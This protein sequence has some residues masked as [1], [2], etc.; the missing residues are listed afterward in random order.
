MGIKDNQATQ[1]K[2][3]WEDKYS[4]QPKF[5][6]FKHF[7]NPKNPNDKMFVNLL[8]NIQGK[9]ILEIGCGNG[10]ISLYWEHPTYSI[11]KNA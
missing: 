5:Q 7:P 9:E 2:E 11:S 8:G 4:N 6:Q 1:S 3:F 10:S